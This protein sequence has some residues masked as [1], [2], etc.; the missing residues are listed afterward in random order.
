M[1]RSCC[2]PPTRWPTIADAGTT[3]PLA[4]S[5]VLTDEGL[6]PGGDEAAVAL[7]VATHPHQDHIGGMAKVLAGLGDRVAEFWDPG[8]FHPIGASHQMMA[9][10]E[11]RTSLLYSYPAAGLNRWIGRTQ[12][13]VLS[14]SIHLRNRFDTYGVEINDSSISLRLQHL[15]AR[16]ITRDLQGNVAT[17][18]RPR[19]AGARRRRPDAV[20]VL[21]AHRLPVPDEVELGELNGDRRRHRRCE[22]APRRRVQGVAPCLEA[23]GNLELLERINPRLTII[24][25][26]QIPRAT[27]S[28]TRWPK[29]SCARP[30]TPEPDPGHG[31][32]SR[33]GNWVSSTPRTATVVIPWAVWSPSSR[34]DENPR[35]GGSATHPT[36]HPPPRDWAALN[37]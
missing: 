28:P 21:R 14:P 22:P 6:L 27:T 2:C 20:L 19:L 35:C 16:V 29:R 26:A 9:E 8:Y 18:T 7:V 25:C 32:R 30:A 33:T 4:L 17:R 36:D 1:R 10:V 5:R 12:I 37:G 3:K 11:A 34:N 13:T 31:G 15:A 23:R 24:S